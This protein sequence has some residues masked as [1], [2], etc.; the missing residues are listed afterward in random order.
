MNKLKKISFIILNLII[1]NNPGI[2]LLG[3]LNKYLLGSRIKSIFIMYPASKK[4]SDRYVFDWYAERIKW[5]PALV[6]ILKQNSFWSLVFG[7]T[8]MEADFYEEKNL[9]NLIN[10]EKRT[11][12]IKN[13]AEAENKRFAGILPSI[14]ASKK[15]TNVSAENS[16]TVQAVIEAVKQLILRLKLASD[17]PIIL[18]GSEGFIGKR[19]FEA[20]DG[21]GKIYPIDIK[22]SEQ[23]GDWP[24]HLKGKNVIILNITKK[25]ALSRYIDSLWKE[26]VI[27]NEVY[28]EPDELEIKRIRKT[29]ARI[30]HIV[31]V[32]G[33]AWPSFPSAYSGGIPCCASYLPRDE[34]LD[35]IIKEL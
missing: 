18:L 24:I 31:G 11:E 30:F 22:N 3:I 27:L 1:N 15:I 28:P 26:S 16:A 17:T 12:K 33:K 32:K 23:I 29:G 34:K 19:F 2:Y 9:E 7:I 4:H 35:V 6:G 8:A 5:K 21:G 13:L 25:N 20:Y 14:F 10:L